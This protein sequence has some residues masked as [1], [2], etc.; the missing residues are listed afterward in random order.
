MT[1][2]ATRIEWIGT[3]L[4]ECGPRGSSARLVGVAI[5]NHAKRNGTGAYPSQRTLEMKT[6]L[7]RPTVASAIKQLVNSGWLAER[8]MRKGSFGKTINEYVLTF[9]ED[10]TVPESVPQ[11][12]SD[13]QANGQ[14]NGQP[15]GQV[16][17]KAICPELI[18]HNPKLITQERTL[19]RPETPGIA[20][21]VLREKTIGQLDLGEEAITI[22]QEAR[23]GA[24]PLEVIRKFRERFG[25]GSAAGW[26][27][28]LKTFAIREHLSDDE[29]RAQEKAK[30]NGAG[31]RRPGETAQEYRYRSQDPAI[32]PEIASAIRGVTK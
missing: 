31:P 12:L 30:Y 25:N 17:G 4:S 2:L 26:R 11:W 15:N 32:S 24:D 18:T 1:R 5:A 14:L 8:P 20:E 27:R 10:G 29:Q 16:I 7:S 19:S 6:D 3:V 21:E 23:P 13:G 22:C 28:A 9:P